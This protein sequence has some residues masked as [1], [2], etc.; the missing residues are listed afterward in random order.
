MDGKKK[1]LIENVFT[2]GADTLLNLGKA[3]LCKQPFPVCDMPGFKKL[4]S[5]YG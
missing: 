5:T 2:G 1:Y 3:A 4:A